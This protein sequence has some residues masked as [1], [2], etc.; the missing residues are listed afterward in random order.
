MSG[1]I[2]SSPDGANVNRVD[3]KAEKAEK[4]RQA[5]FG[6]IVEGSKKTEAGWQ[7]I[8]GD[9]IID[10]NNL[11]AELPHMSK[12]D[13][14]TLDE[15]MRLSSNARFGRENEEAKAKHDEAVG[16]VKQD[17]DDEVKGRSEADAA[18]FGVD[19]DTLDVFTE[20][21]SRQG[22]GQSTTAERDY[23]GDTIETH[24]GRNQ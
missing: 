24:H 10:V 14:D 2:S 11:A 15:S 3:L 21:G 19:Q 17:L 13:I 12:S 8:L 18:D 23:E 1:E 5:M 7:V 20:E 16:A 6:R 22:S 4:R 9:K